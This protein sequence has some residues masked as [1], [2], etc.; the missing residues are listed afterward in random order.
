MLKH[1]TGYQQHATIAT[2]KVR[3]LRTHMSIWLSVPL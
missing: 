3:V 2:L 1:K